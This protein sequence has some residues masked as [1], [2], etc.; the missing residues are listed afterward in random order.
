M[1]TVG[2]VA[3]DAKMFGKQMSAAL[4]HVVQ[5]NHKA[6]SGKKMHPAVRQIAE[7]GKLE[8][9]HAIAGGR[10]SLGSRSSRDCPTIDDSCSES[11]PRPQ[12]QQA[13][14]AGDVPTS[15][16]SIW[17]AYGVKPPTGMKLDMGPRTLQAKVS[18][19]ISITSSPGKAPL[20]AFHNE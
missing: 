2:M 8:P 19:A 12:Q 4:S 3:D 7:V 20:D 14:T 1:N 13:R 18:E 9:G 15:P 11:P 5:K 17:R 10:T 16:R 6:I